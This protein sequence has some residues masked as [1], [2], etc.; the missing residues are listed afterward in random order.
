MSENDS[1]LATEYMFKLIPWGVKWFNNHNQRLKQLIET[2]LDNTEYEINVGYETDKKGNENVV[3]W[4]T[5]TPKSKT[6]LLKRYTN[7]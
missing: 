5:Y 6:E 3:Y 7:G 1:D 4:L 2:I